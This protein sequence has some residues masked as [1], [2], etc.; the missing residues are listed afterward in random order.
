MVRPVHPDHKAE[1]WHAAR[2]ATETLTFTVDASV[3][4][5]VFL[6]FDLVAAASCDGDDRPARPH[7]R[8]L[9]SSDTASRKISYQRFSRVENGTAAARTA[10]KC[11]PRNSNKFY[12]VDLQ[13][14]DSH[15]RIRAANLHN[16]FSDYIFGSSQRHR[17]ERC[18]DFAAIRRF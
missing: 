6:R 9:K 7:M 16:R 10:V 18:Q 12:S 8:I 5:Q 11:S 13:Q 15:L 1:P 17:R 4:R 14:L 3:V 2:G